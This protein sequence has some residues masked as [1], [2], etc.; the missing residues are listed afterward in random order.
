VLES[1]TLAEVAGGEL[2]WRIEAVLND[3]EA[4]LKR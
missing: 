2:P 1:A 3:P 4:W